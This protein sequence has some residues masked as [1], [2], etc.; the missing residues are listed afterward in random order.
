MKLNN[1]YSKS[2][3]AVTMA[4]DNDQKDA[5]GTEGERPGNKPPPDEDDDLPTPPTKRGPMSQA[6]GGW[7]WLVVLGA[8]LVNM[9]FGINYRVFG[10]V[11][12]EMRQRFQASATAC[13]WVGGLNLLLGGFCGELLI[14]KYKKLFSF[15]FR[16]RMPSLSSSYTISG[17]V[18]VC[19]LLFQCFVLKPAKIPKS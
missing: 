15:L 10:L 18:P 8:A 2:H 5:G 13:V 11:Y 17:P 12:L 9:M 1:Q 14:T 7:G 6:E 3:S 19:W 4:S 16:D